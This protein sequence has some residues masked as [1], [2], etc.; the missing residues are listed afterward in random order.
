MDAATRDHAIWLGLAHRQGLVLAQ[1]G[2]P[3]SI[4]DITAVVGR[5]I[6]PNATGAVIMSLSRRGLIERADRVVQS[7]HA[8][9]HAHANPVWV[10]TLRAR[11]EAPVGHL[12]PNAAS[13]TRTGTGC[14]RCG[15]ELRH[16]R[17]TLAAGISEGRCRKDG[18]Q[19]IKEPVLAG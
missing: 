7:R 3:F 14:P 5:P 8:S 18:W 15:G 16:I 19:A 4:D 2:D 10:G 12:L 13:A 9:T 17:P 1:S 6:R 11:S